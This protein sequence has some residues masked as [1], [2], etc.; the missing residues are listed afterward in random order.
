MRCFSLPKKKAVVQKIAGLCGI[1]G[2]LVAL[3][4]IALAISDSLSWFSWK[5][6]ALSDLA[7]TQATATAATIFNS[8]LIICALLSIVF[9]VGL[10]QILQK[11]TLGF[12]GV[13]ILAL[14][15]VSLFAIGVFPETAG[16]IHLY[17][18][19]AFFALFPISLL[20]IGA[21]MIE[22]E[23]QRNLGFVTILF[24]M[25]AVMSAAPLIL[26]EVDDVGIHELL[27]ALSGL[28]WS[29]VVGIKL[30]RQPILRA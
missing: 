11:R 1:I 6:N 26:A 18:S 30:Y 3:S 14:S 27:A 9:A 25:F 10:M 22:E 2:P 23:S 19:V 16:R 24:S 5:T 20:F 13:F 21:S 15:D 29:I 7:G 28:A 4:F 12:I 8:G 17:V